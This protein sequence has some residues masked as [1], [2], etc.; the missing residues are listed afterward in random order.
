VKELEELGIQQS[1][2]FAA[3]QST[4]WGAWDCATQDEVEENLRTLAL[5]EFL[6][7]DIS[8]LSDEEQ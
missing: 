5:Y 7:I 2:Y 4:I 3:D 6:N 1:I 8:P